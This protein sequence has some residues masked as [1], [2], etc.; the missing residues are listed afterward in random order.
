MSIE[1]KA[2]LHYLNDAL[3]KFIN[4]LNKFISLARIL[5]ILTIEKMMDTIMSQIWATNDIIMEIIS[6]YRLNRKGKQGQE[7]LI[8]IMDRGKEDK[9][10]KIGF[11]LSEMVIDIDKKYII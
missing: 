6:K 10:T 8:I 4:L 7:W 1:S 3:N 9:T 11:L 5:N 2:S